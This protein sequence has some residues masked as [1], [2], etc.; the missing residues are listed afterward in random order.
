MYCQNTEI[1]ILM[2]D[3]ISCFLVNYYKEEQLKTDINI[4]FDNYV[5]RT[6]YHF[7]SISL[8]IFRFQM[9][10][11]QVKFFRL[12]EKNLEEIKLF[13]FIR[14]KNFFGKLEEEEIHQPF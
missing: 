13:R 1:D 14:E 10:R 6:Y 4:Y 7:H 2:R 3:I 12:G 11:L 5:S 8:I 9:A